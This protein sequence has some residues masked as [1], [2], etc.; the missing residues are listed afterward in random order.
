MINQRIKNTFILIDAIEF[1]L[2]HNISG[3]NNYTFSILSSTYQE[4]R[5]YISYQIQYFYI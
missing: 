4:L 2:F 3:V 5:V 1:E